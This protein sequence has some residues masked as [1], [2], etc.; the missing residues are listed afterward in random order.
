MLLTFKQEIQAADKETGIISG[1][2]A[3]YGQ[4]GFTSAGAVM[5]ER[6][7]IAIA[8]ATKIKL[9]SQHQQDMPVGRAIS[10]TDDERWRLR[11]FQGI[12]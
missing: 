5:F 1:M 10:F 12:R 8:D 4:I 2:V 7:S 11:I 9:L 6:G 3:P